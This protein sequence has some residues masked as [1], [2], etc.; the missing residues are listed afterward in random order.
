MLLQAYLY[1][2]AMTVLICGTDQRKLGIERPMNIMERISNEVLQ[3]EKRKLSN[4]RYDDF[5]LPSRSTRT[6]TKQKELHSGKT[7]VSRNM[8]Y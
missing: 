3:E 4:E 6:K 1:L 8:K 5:T 7:Y 2:W